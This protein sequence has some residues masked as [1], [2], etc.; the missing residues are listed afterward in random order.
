M[1]RKFAL[2]SLICLA[3]ASRLPAQT[4]T[5]EDTE[6]CQ[7]FTQA[8]YNWYVAKV[9][10]SF[11]D[12]NA[13]PLL[14]GLDYKGHPF[15]RGL[16]Q[17]IRK[18]RAEEVKSHGAILDFDPIL[19]SQDPAEHYLVRNVTEKDGRYL[20]EIYGVWHTPPSDLRKGP[21]VVAEI[22]YRQGRWVF[23]NFH[24]PGSPFPESENLVSILKSA[25]R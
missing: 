13:D 7:R 14:E 5:R 15:S 1:N 11:H 20:A 18:V 17:G 9:F 4:R 21:Q 23:V 19:N 6:S 2:L 10:Q 16:V 24:Y 22:I 3:C 8:F 25:L 12:K